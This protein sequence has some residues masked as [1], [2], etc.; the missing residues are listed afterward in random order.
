MAFVDAS[1]R[2]R[3]AAM[4]RT[5]ACVNLARPLGTAAGAEPPRSS[6]TATFEQRGQLTVGFDRLEATQHGV[7]HTHLDAW[8]HYGVDGTFFPGVAVDA[9]AEASVV[10]WARL[11]VVTRAVMLDLTQVRGTPW[12]AAEAPVSGHDLDEALA[13]AGVSLSRG[14][15]LLAYMGRDRFEAAGH[16]YPGVPAAVA[17]GRPRPGLGRSAAEWIARHEVS[18]VCWDFLDAVHPD[19]PPAPV[20]L[21][22]WA[23]GL[24]LVDNC[25]LGAARRFLASQGRSDA[26]VVIAPLLAPNATASLVS[27]LLVC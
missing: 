22:I 24:G 18:V 8:S 1:A 7:E 15:A 13:N 26:M 2:L 20:H 19:E 9:A 27:P 10:A 6:V 23:I 11:G 21:L 3:A 16:R 17:S 14:D 5:G 12:V 25:D 4:V